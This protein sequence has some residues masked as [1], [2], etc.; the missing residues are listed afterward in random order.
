MWDCENA[1]REQQL[2]EHGRS[3]PRRWSPAPATVDGKV[4][5]W[6]RFTNSQLAR[7]NRVFQVRGPWVWIVE[8]ISQPPRC[9]PIQL[10]ETRLNSILIPGAPQQPHLA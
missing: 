6:S 4:R 7:L 2:L 9:N 10:L 1:S 8:A 5:R 3:Y